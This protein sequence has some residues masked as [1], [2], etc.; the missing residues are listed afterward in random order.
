MMKIRQQKSLFPVAKVVIV[1]DIAS[2]TAITE[3]LLVRFAI[4]ITFM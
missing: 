4:F 2:V 1:Y 3:V